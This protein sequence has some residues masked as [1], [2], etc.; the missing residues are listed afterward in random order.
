[1]KTI[2][3]KVTFTTSWLLRHWITEW[4]L[5]FLTDL[6]SYA[7]VLKKL[8]LFPDSWS[9]LLKF[10]AISIHIHRKTVMQLSIHGRPRLVWPMTSSLWNFSF[11]EDGK[12]C[13]SFLWI[14]LW[15]AD[16]RAISSMSLSIRLIVHRTKFCNLNYMYN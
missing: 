1:M 13:S 5:F 11:M 14:A 8:L 10:S 6:D 9:Q 4:P 12:P 15:S 16:R 3:K 2:K 7:I